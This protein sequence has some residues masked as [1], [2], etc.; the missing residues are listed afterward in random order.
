MTKPAYRTELESHMYINGKIQS[1]NG[2][3]DNV[4]WNPGYGQSVPERSY[5]KGAECPLRYVTL[6]SCNER[7][8]AHEWWY[9][10]EDDIDCMSVSKEARL[11]HT[12]SHST[13]VWTEYLQCSVYGDEKYGKI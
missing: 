9:H 4:A 5:R 12:V 3:H 13:D 10:G 1:T 8:G 2:D 7:Q 6:S 11:L